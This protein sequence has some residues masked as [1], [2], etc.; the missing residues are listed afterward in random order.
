M[1]VAGFTSIA[2]EVNSS[3]LV[4]GLLTSKRHVNRETLE[5]T[6]SQTSVSFTPSTVLDL[7]GNANRALIKDRRCQWD[8][9]NTK[10]KAVGIGQLL[11][12]TMTQA[13]VPKEL[14]S[15]GRESVDWQSIGCGG[16][17]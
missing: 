7:G 4:L 16:V 1:D 12:R 6:G 3:V 13:L 2:S 10:C 9:G 8:L 14:G 15:L 11:I 5:G 17:G